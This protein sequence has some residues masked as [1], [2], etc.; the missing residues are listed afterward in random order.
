MKIKGQF[1]FNDEGNL[2]YM[3]LREWVKQLDLKPLQPYLFKTNLRGKTATVYYRGG[4]GVKWEDLQDH[5]DELFYVN[6]A[7]LDS[8]S[9]HYKNW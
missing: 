4:Y 3:T 9:I 6:N 5:F 1:I 2:L 7:D 8:I